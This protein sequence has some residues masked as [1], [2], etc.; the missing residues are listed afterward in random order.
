MVS[1]KAILYNNKNTEAL[2]EVTPQENPI[3]VQLFGSDPQ[4]MAEY[5]KENRGKT[6]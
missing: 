5:S 4:I 2:L 1:A 6:I 3:S